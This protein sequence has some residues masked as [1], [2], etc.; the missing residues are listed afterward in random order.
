MDQ[1]I[2][3]AH[4]V[5]RGDGGTPDALPG[6]APVGAVLE[7]AEEGGSCRLGSRVSMT[8]CPENLNL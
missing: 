8:K 5:E 3:K 2:V 7:D 4:F 6:H 1:V